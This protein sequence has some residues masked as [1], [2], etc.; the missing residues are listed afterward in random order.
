M[1]RG[2]W[3]TS[4]NRSGSIG[5]FLEDKDE[6]EEGTVGQGEEEELGEGEDGSDEEQEDEDQGHA[7]NQ[8]FVPTM[9][10][11]KAKKLRKMGTRLKIA[12]RLC[13]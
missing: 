4:R 1:T 3:Y 7:D 12:R 9:E 13:C 2:D 11:A 10:R 5:D 6:E 8:W